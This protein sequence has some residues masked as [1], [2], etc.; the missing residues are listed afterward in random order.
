M[1]LL[2]T[3]SSKEK[4]EGGLLKFKEPLE[5]RGHPE[6]FIERSLS[7]VNFASRQSV[8]THTQKPKDHG[9]LLPSVTTYHPAV[10]N[11]KQILMEH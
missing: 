8:L 10:K 1:R 2:R 4:F 5:A 6:N 11:L 9:Y 3:K 7:G